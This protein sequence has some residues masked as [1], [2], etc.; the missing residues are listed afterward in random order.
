MAQV[1]NLGL[2]LLLAGQVSALTANPEGLRVRQYPPTL[3]VIRGETATLSC[4]F[5][6]DSLKYGVQWFKMKP[7]KQ[8]LPK[9]SRQMVVEKNQTSYL[10][11]TEVALE[12]F[13]WYYCEV[14]VLQRDPEWGNGTELVVLAPPSPPRIYLRTPPDTHTGQW[15]LLCLTG[16]FHPNE[17]NLTWTYQSTAVNINH[18]S[19]T[20]CTIPAIN[21]PG[22]LSDRALLSSDWLVNSMPLHRSKCFQVIDN[23]SRE[24]FLFSV[25]SLPPKQSLHTGITFTCRVEAHPALTTA[26]TASFTWDA[27]PN[28]L[29]VHLNIL[30]MC[31]LSAMTVVFLWEGG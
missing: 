24:V 20:N 16:G 11:I 30:K 21:P 12:D 17:L 2:F 31:V 10:L 29:I 27:S 22:S 18:L 7:E 13:G 25:F 3:T 8:L 26:L 28:E 14:N 9:S 1:T 19:V 6:V 4:S 5:Q 23:H 15:A